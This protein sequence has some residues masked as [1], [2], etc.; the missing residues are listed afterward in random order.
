MGTLSGEIYRH[1]KIY[2]LNISYNNFTVIDVGTNIRAALVSTDDYRICC[3]IR[4]EKTVCLREPKWPHTCNSVLEENTLKLLGFFEGTFVLI[5]NLLSIGRTPFTSLEDKKLT[6]IIFR[7]VLSTN[8][9][10]FGIY[11]ISTFIQDNQYSSQYVLYDE[12]WRASYFCFGLG[13]LFLFASLYSMFLS[14]L[15]TISRLVAVTLPFNSHFKRLKIAKRYLVAGGICSL[16]FCI[17]VTLSY[18]VIEEKSTMPFSNCLFLGGNFN[19]S[20]LKTSTITLAVMQVIV[21]LSIFTMYIIIVN[22]NNKPLTFQKANIQKMKERAILLIF[23]NTICWLP[24]S[25]ILITSVTMETYPVALLTWY[26]VVI[27]PINPITNPIL[28]SSLPSLSTIYVFV[29]NKHLF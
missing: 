29:V 9:M 24:S 27:S 21:L 7:N 6:F 2:I 4:S 20:T 13:F 28:F 5:L 14:T 17:T 12:D 26:A 1:L 16:S 25:A 8:D 10:I 23:S 11:L 19:S 15:I 22:N 18:L 3:L